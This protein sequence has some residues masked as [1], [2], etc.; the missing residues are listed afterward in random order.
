MCP[1][2]LDKSSLS[3]GRVNELNVKLLINEI[4]HLSNCMY[5]FFKAL[6]AVVTEH[7]CHQDTKRLEYVVYDV[8]FHSNNDV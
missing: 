2:A 7:M 6:F 1:C 3:I 4:D 8:C 5:S